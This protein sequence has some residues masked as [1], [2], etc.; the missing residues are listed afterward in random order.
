MT[1]AIALALSALPAD[2]PVCNSSRYL[3]R[4]QPL[5][6]A[7]RLP[8]RKKTG[9]CTST[10]IKRQ[11]WAQRAFVLSAAAVQASREQ[12]PKKLLYAVIMGVARNFS[13]GGQTRMS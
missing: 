7:K 11:L 8:N 2:A 1:R 13:R 9:V 3:V 6:Q 10:L 12:E 4:R 5:P